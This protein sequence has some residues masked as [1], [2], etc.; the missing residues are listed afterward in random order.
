MAVS[1]KTRSRKA[2]TSKELKVD[3]QEAKP[4]AGKQEMPNGKQE[5]NEPGAPETNGASGDFQK[6]SPWKFIVAFMIVIVA[7][8]V[9]SILLR[10]ESS[11]EYSSY[12]GFS[13]KQVRH[14]NSLLWV[15]RVEVRGQ[16][17]DIPFYYHPKDTEDVVFEP[18]LA[19][20]IVDAPVKPRLVYMSFDPDSGSRTVVAGVE[21]SRLLGTRYNLMNMKV[22]SALTREAE[23]G[24]EHLVKTCED[25]S[26]GILVLVFSQGVVNAVDHESNCIRISYTTPEDSIR[27]ADWF[28]YEMLKII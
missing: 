19:D 6:I 22:Q 27:V 5:T 23:T 7:V 11:D 2:K 26:D 25:A 12:N 4:K 24:T 9:V 16:P 18:G 13:F 20:A 21:I 17:Y 3:K 10:P 8:V 15:T 14:G 1:A 28:A